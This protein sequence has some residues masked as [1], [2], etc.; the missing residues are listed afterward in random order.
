MVTPSMEK[1]APSE[2]EKYQTMIKVAIVILNW[3]GEKLLPQFLPSVIAHSKIVGAEVIVADNAS[4]DASL[5]VMNS[6]FPDVRCITMVKNHGFAE[7]YNQALQ[8]VEAEYYI[9]LNSD[10][11]VTPRWLEPMLDYMD[12]HAD[13]AACGP[14]ILDYKK[15]THFEYAGAA[16]GFIDHYGFPFCRGRIFDEIEEDRGQYDTVRDVL[17]ASGC[18]LMVR[19]K[20]YHEHGGLD[21]D[22]FAHME[23]ID[24]CW[25][26]NNRGLRVVNIPESKVYHVGG[27]SLNATSP[28]KTYLNFRNSLLMIYKNTDDKLLNKVLKR[29]RRLDFIAAVKFLLT[30]GT[31]HY[32]AVFQAHQDFQK[33]IPKFEAKRNENLEKKKRSYHLVLKDSIVTCYYLG[34]KK[35]FTDYVI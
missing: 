12:A 3:N 6:Q 29:R 32:E 23:E 22:F 33:A 2:R 5:A 18:A 14:K 8:Q 13:V 31:E 16:G 4:T 15:K 30:N 24:F 34:R 1:K 26:L 35:R 27:A 10:V 19:A 11:E 25:R 20:D 7:G 28:H 9:L 21:K 17:W